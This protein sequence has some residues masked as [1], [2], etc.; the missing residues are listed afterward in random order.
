MEYNE[1]SLT[2]VIAVKKE[3]LILA[4]VVAVFIAG[5]LVL[6]SSGLLPEENA[7]NFNALSKISLKTDNVVIKEPTAGDNTYIYAINDVAKKAWEIAEKDPKVQ[8]ILTQIKGSAVTIA[9]VQPTAFVNPDGSVSHSGAGQVII[10][11]NWQLVGGRPYTDAESF[12]SV[13]GMQGE[14]HQK[15]WNIIVDLDSQKVVDISNEN[16]RIMSQNLRTNIIYAGMNMFMPD[17]VKT[18]AGSSV[19][20]INESNLPHNVVG[21]YKTAAGKTIQVDSGFFNSNESFQYKFP[22]KGVFN[23]HCTIH[24]EEGM[25]GTII[26]S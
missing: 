4:A 25:K 5:G 6:M 16:E 8:D 19:Q 15:I 10:T 7:K 20:W 14:S 22:E 26:V 23:Y 1:Y 11:A 12:A 13:A 24:S 18:N 17:V 9:A 21:T 3:L 2:I